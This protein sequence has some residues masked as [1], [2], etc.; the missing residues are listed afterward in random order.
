MC[1]D[2]DEHHSYNLIISPIFEMRKPKYI[3]IKEF[4]TDHSS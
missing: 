4:T 1:L 2:S 3:E